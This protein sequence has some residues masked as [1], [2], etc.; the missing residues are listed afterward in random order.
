MSPSTHV[1]PNFKSLAEVSDQG[2]LDE[3]LQHMA[4]MTAGM[5]G[6]ENCSI[7]LA[8]EDGQSRPRLSVWACTGNLPPAA[9]REAETDMVGLASRVLAAGEAVRIDDIG[10]SAFADCARRIDDPRRSLLCAPIRIH[11]NP[12]GVVNVSGRMAAGP[13]SADDLRLLEVIALFIGK[14]IQVSQL[15][16]MLD[17]R[18]AQMAVI[19]EATRGLGDSLAAGLPNPDQVAKIMAK[20]F[21]KE[22]TRAGFGSRQIINAASEIITQLSGHLQRHNKRLGRAPHGDPAATGDDVL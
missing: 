4:G 19:Q 17:S 12:L 9:Y 11:A 5:L 16:S 22:M 15:Q 20:S 14:A 8:E 3:H 6:A 18:F 21:Y 7:M 1:L 10:D 13:F 2:S